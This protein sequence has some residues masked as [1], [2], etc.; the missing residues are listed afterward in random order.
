[1]QSINPTDKVSVLLTIHYLSPKKPDQ[2]SISYEFIYGI[3]TYGLCPLELAINSKAVGDE[4][5]I[6]ISC[7]SWL[8]LFGHLPAPYL[9]EVLNLHEM[10]IKAQI[11]SIVPAQDKEVIQALSNLTRCQG[12]CDCGCN[13]H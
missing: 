12:G 13:D 3:G 7:N 2:N 5:E 6:N 11:T 1:M 10:K 4:F 8:D 9:K